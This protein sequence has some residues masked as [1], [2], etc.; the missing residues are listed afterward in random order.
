MGD[1]LAH[2]KGIEKL[3]VAKTTLDILKSTCTSE[4][5]YEDVLNQTDVIETSA[6]NM[7]NLQQLEQFVLTH[8]Q[9]IRKQS[10][11]V[12]SIMTMLHEAEMTAEQ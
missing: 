11:K 12:K 2:L 10:E 5:I 4:G 1:S 8:I 7:Y 9:R 3:M 6:R